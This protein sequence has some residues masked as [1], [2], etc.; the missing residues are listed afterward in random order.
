M[1]CCACHSAECAKK[2]VHKNLVGLPVVNCTACV[3]SCF[4]KRKSVSQ[5]RA[6]PRHE[7]PGVT[8]CSLPPARNNIPALSQPNSVGTRLSDPGWMQSWLDLVG[9]YI[10]RS[11][12]HPQIV[13]HP[14]TNRARRK[15]TSF[16]CRSTLPLWRRHLHITLNK[17][18]CLGKLH[19]F[20]FTARC[21]A[22]AVLAMGLCLCL[23]VCLSVSVCHKPVFY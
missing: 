6:Y 4:N 11:Y 19:A 22:S 3:L 10:P 13:T 15:T 9:W 5:S 21:Y 18:S 7:R 16:I 2:C 20:I 17:I 8:Q 14:S 23:S 12:I 1:L